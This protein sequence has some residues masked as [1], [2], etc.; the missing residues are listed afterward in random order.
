MAPSISC[1]SWAIVVAGDQSVGHDLPAFHLRKEARNELGLVLTPALILLPWVLSNHQEP[2][3]PPC[4][5]LPGLGPI[6]S[7]KICGV[8]FS[9]CSA[10]SVFLSG[11]SVCLILLVLWWSSFFG[12]L[13]LLSPAY[14]LG[15]S[16]DM[17]CA[18][19]PSFQCA[20]RA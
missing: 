17:N 20:S 2:E 19:F 5:H 15:I 16:G 7:A 6:F 10:C 4:L 18:F 1:S 3:A 12:F 13:L 8:V 11:V 9:T 14:C